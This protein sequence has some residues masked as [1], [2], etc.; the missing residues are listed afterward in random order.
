M[1]TDLINLFA[2]IIGFVLQSSSGLP[3]VPSTHLSAHQQGISESAELSQAREM[4]TTAVKLYNAGKYKEALDPA[5]RALLITESALPANDDRVIAAVDNLAAIYAALH[6]YKEA[7]GLYKRILASHEAKSGLESIDVA[8]TLNVL[9]ALHHVRGDV[10][11]A[12]AE[13]ERALTIRDKKGGGKTN[14][15]ARTVFQLAELYQGEANLVKAE[16]LYRRLMMF[17]EGVVLEEKITVGEARHRL[18][19]LLQKL[20]RQAEAS[21]LFRDRNKASTEQEGSPRVNDG[22]ILNGRALRLQAPAVPDKAWEARASGQVI[23]VLTISEGGKVIRACAVK[24]HPLLWDPSE[25]A[26]LAS[27][28]APTKLNGE[29][30]KVTGVIT[31]NFGR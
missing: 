21:E 15:A 6:K 16:P 30:V 1:R 2:L 22:G 18:A 23:V 26:A 5:K 28:F 4:S 3:N 27:E 31:Y 29:A 9:A 25:R 19:C 7:E 13:Y 20:N 8:A 10:K 17:D 12:A 11:Q 24:G 14:E